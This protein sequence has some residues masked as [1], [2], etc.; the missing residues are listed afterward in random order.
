M[1][2]VFIRNIFKI[3]LQGG[4]VA[5]K[6]YSYCAGVGKVTF[7]YLPVHFFILINKHFLKN[8]VPRFINYVN[9][10]RFANCPHTKNNLYRSNLSFKNISLNE[11]ELRTRVSLAR[12]L[13]ITKHCAVRLCL[14]ASSKTRAKPSWTKANSSR[15]LKQPAGNAQ[16]RMKLTFKLSL[17]FLDLSRWPLMPSFYNFITRES[18]IRISAIRKLWIMLSLWQA[19]ALKSQSHFGSS[20]IGYL[21]LQFLFILL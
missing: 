20:R 6:D 13:A 9:I 3:S 5:E 14:I 15:I 1:S 11:N 16:A 19:G 18:L 21:T 8:F 7:T 10:L 2:I 17:P 4:I 12:R